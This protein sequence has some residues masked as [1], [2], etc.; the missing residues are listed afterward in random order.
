V[1]CPRGNE[2]LKRQ[3]KA[4]AHGG[5]ETVVSLLQVKEA[6]R[7]GLEDEAI[8]AKKAGMKFLSFPVPDHSLPPDL[9]AFQEFVAGLATRVRKGERIGVHCLGSIGRSTITTA[10]TLVELGFDAAD[11]L[12]AIER[13]RGCPVPDTPAQEQWILQYR[14]KR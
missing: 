14:A 9:P 12:E 13:V 6:S 1:L 3:M 5:I 4:L 11:A 2:M 7:L 8:M 10:C